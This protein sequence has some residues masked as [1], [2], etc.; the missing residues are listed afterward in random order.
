[1]TPS[2]SFWGSKREI[3]TS[4]GRRK[5]TSHLTNRAV[6][7]SGRQFHVLDGDWID[8]RRNDNDSPNFQIRRLEGLHREDGSILFLNVGMQEFPYFPVGLRTVDVASPNPLGARWR[9]LK[10]PW[11]CRLRVM[12]DKEVVV[13]WEHFSARPLGNL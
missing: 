12:D 2:G 9:F 4:S 5:S 6:T 13:R 1:M 3:C 11:R 7:D 10:V 8:R